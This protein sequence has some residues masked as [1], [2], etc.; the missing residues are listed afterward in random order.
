MVTPLLM[1]EFPS[2][3]IILFWKNTRISYRYELCQPNNLFYR[4][5]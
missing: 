1:G 4:I 2:L 3:M 5:G